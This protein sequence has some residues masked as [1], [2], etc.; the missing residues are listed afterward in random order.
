MPLKY[1]DNSLIIHFVAPANPFAL[2]ITFEVLLEGAGTQWVSTGAVGSASFNHLKEGDYVFRVR[3][4]AGGVTPGAEARLQFTVQPP[5]FR[6]PLAWGLYIAA[7]AALFAFVTWL[8]SY[9]QRRENARLELLVVSRTSELNATNTQL[10]RQIQETTEKSAALSVSEERYRMLNA[11]LERRVEERTAKLAEASGLLDAMLANTPDLIYFKD[12]ESRFVRFSRAFAAR[13]NL[14]DPELI[15]G[16]TD[17]DFF[18][19]NHAQL[20]FADEQEIIRTGHPIIGKLEKETYVDG[21]VTW[22]LTTKMPWLDGTGTIIGTFGIS[23]DVTAWKEAEARLADTHLQLL[24]TSR[25]AGMAEVATG[26]LHNVGNVLNSVNVSATLVAEHVRHT[27]AG[28]IAKLAALFEE[29]KADLA[30]FLTKDARGQMI[31]AYLGT[32]AESLA[33]EQKTLLTELEHLYKNVEHIKEIVSMQQA[34]AGSSGVIETIS[35]PDLIEDAL[36]I[37]AGSLA[38][39]AVDTIRD[40]QA[41]PVVTTDKHKVMQILVNLVRNATQACDESGRTD[42]QITV[43]TTSDVRSAHIAISDNGVGIPAENL[44]RIFNHGFTTRKSGHGFGLHSGALAARELGG[45]L[46]V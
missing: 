21:R 7:T 25:H 13:F 40:Y 26:V 16:K 19:A 45:S 5:W 14:T 1:A 15:R 42:K 18:D 35:V 28:N 29:H 17:F 12:R 41:R 43:R 10:G 3:P 24:E 2:P 9:L 6:T 27:Q 34:Y 30:G 38:R 44:D 32:L 37:N 22:A 33:T 39:H 31:P 20:A 23:M 4:V 8:S 11:E 46:R 36:R